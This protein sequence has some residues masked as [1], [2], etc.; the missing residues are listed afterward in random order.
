MPTQMLFPCGHKRPI[1]WV[2]RDRGHTVLLKTNEYI[3]FS[4]PECGELFE[5]SGI[6][7]R[8]HKPARVVKPEPKPEPEVETATPDVTKDIPVAKPTKGKGR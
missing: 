3:R 7:E 8:V 5:Y 6:I 1:E 2:F 4:C